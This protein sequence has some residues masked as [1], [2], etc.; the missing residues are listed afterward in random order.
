MGAV[1]PRNI[2]PNRPLTGGPRFKR[3]LSRP[4]VGMMGLG[5]VYFSVVRPEESKQTMQ[6]GIEFFFLLKKGF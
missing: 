1:R 3:L 2:H 4:G 6:L 5:T